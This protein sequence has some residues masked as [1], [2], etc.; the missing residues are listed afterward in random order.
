MS[1]KN[2]GPEYI[3]QVSHYKTKFKSTIV[4]VNI[5]SIT[6]ITHSERIKINKICNPNKH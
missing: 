5:I 6:C 4:T 3:A 2:E 1:L